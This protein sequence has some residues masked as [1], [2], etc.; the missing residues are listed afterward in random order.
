MAASENKQDQKVTAAVD[1]LNGPLKEIRVSPQLNENI[2]TM[3]S[4]FEKDETFILREVETQS[5]P[6]V[7]FALVYCAGMV[8]SAIIGDNIIRPLTA[9]KLSDTGKNLYETVLTEILYIHN[10]TAASGFQDIVE[11][12]TSGDTALFIPQ[13]RE[14]LILGTQGFPL[15]GIEEPAG[16]SILSGPKEGFCES[17]VTNLSFIHRRLRT[18]DLKMEM[19]VFGSRTRTKACICYLRQL[20]KPAIL[21]ELIRR[22]DTINIDGVLDAN[23]LNELIRDNPLSPFR[24]TG[25]TERPDVVV[26]KLLEGRIAIFLDGTPVVLTVPYLFIENFQSNEDYYLNFYYTSFSR[27]LRIAGFLVTITV[28]ALYLAVT[29]HH[30][31]LLPT[32]LLINI[33]N[34]RLNVPFPMWLELLALLLAFDVLRETGIRMPSGVGQAM[35]VVGALVLGTAAVEAKIASSLVI[36]VVALSGIT[37][38]LIPK[39][40]APNIIVRL[41]LFACASLEGLPGFA[42]GCIIIL[43]HILS[44]KSL[45]VW[46][47]SASGNM[48]FQHNKDILFRA[49]L[50]KMQERPDS[51]A[52]GKKRMATRKRGWWH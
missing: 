25:Y 15:R 37:S 3:K 35:S 32:P 49:P 2:R 48:N 27:M 9:A 8:D 22:L 14:A 47:V 36:I 44:L 40:N 11:A 45:G 51:I 18:N 46:Q 41:F 1:M 28:P 29:T 6:S 38:L 26:G 30:Q 43:I 17:M 21:N 42:M 7:K 10:P 31:Q 52:T 16:E 24:C 23:Y 4:L 12:V 5:Q 19:R 20:V 39:L 50:W 33:T 13:S 34:E